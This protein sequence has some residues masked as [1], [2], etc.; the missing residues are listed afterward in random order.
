MTEQ[1]D[2][3][4][5]SYVPDDDE[6]EDEKKKDRAGDSKK[7]SAKKR[8]STK[9]LQHDL[10]DYQKKLEAVL[11]E[12]D[13]FKDK[14]LR[15]LAEIDNFRKRVKKEKEDYQKYVLSEF[16][17]DLLQVYDN[18]ERA[19]K[20]KTPADKNESVLSLL[21]DDDEKSIISGVEMIYKQ[22]TDLLKKYKVVE[23]EAHDKPFDPNLHQALSK[24]E[25]EDVQQPMVTEVYQK[26]FLY[27]AKLLKPSLVKVAIPMEKK[28]EPQ[29]QPDQQPQAED[30]IED[31]GDEQ[32][33]RIEIEAED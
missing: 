28:P 30:V 23:I 26:G 1:T 29:P 4:E 25:S 5:I 13:D 16:L 7:K 33:H 20:A 14:Y 10:D 32:P 24:E 31:E 6:H 17:L 8:P 21:K 11:E 15:N 27:N 2:T 3:V 12:R 19:L 18:L 9:K 22:F